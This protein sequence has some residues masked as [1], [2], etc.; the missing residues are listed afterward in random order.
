MAYEDIAITTLQGEHTTFGQFADK[1]VLVV[2]V[3]SR[4]GLAPQY[5]QLEALQRQYA[6]RGFTVL[7]F[8]S[9]QFLQELGSAEAIS[10]YCSTTWGVTFPMSEKVRVN[11]KHAHPLYQ[12]LTKAP[13]DSGK[14]GRI[15]W[16]FEKF[17]IA[18]DGTVRRFRPTT[19]PD[20]PQVIE[21]IEAA[22]PR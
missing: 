14:A 12:E 19:K 4:C 16:N 18:P 9:N 22:L 15:M 7:G 3:A 13:D 10:E 8:P 11:G 2:N 21:A 6:D 17:L 5:E 20:D 1:A